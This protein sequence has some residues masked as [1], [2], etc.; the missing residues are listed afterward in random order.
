MTIEVDSALTDQ[1]MSAWSS[2]LGYLC[3]GICLI[4]FMGWLVRY[5]KQKPINEYDLTYFRALFLISLVMDS[6][7]LLLH[8]GTYAF[9]FWGYP[10]TAWNVAL[11]NFALAGTF[12][13]FI[14]VISRF[15]YT[16]EINY[17]PGE[18]RV[19]FA[20]FQLTKAADKK[21][22]V[23]LMKGLMIYF[24]MIGFYYAFK[25]PF[26]PAPLSNVEKKD[27]YVICLKIMT[28]FGLVFGAWNLKSIYLILI[29][30]DDLS[31]H[32][33]LAGHAK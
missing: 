27:F 20:S 9:N 18:G 32:P 6:M 30:K 31:R 14:N 16:K 29:K 19:P 10:F 11:F 33:A 5:R 24:L 2:P 1:I 4:L 28:A 7:L 25:F 3:I 15:Y 26:D 21:W 23:W 22:V 13:V 17:V 12:C 8:F